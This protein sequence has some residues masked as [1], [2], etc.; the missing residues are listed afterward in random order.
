M[1][2]LLFV[3]LLLSLF[4]V[5]EGFI[6]PLMHSRQRTMDRLLVDYLKLKRS[7][8]SGNHLGKA[9]AANDLWAKPNP[10]M[11]PFVLYLSCSFVLFIS[12]IKKPPLSTSSKAV[13][14]FYF[15]S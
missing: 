11:R 4:I 8:T 9:G 13:L 14:I 6:T 2:T 15:S 10:A 5:Q 3:T 7:R 12:G 1:P